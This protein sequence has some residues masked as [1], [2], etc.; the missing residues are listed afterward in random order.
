MYGVGPAMMIEGKSKF[1]SWWGAFFSLLVILSVL[2][3]SGLKI[4]FTLYNQASNLQQRTL[5]N[6]AGSELG[7]AVLRLN[8]SH[9]SVDFEFRHN[10]NR[11]STDK[12]TPITS[13]ETYM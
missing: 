13:S 2:S 12:E 1:K 6:G 7:E 8:E 5:F 11:F 9:V 10:P 3:Y 4:L